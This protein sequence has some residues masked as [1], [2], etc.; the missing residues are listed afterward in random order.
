MLSE[1]FRSWKYS[2]WR[3]TKSRLEKGRQLPNATTQIQPYRPFD[4]LQ[5][6]IL[7]SEFLKNPTAGDSRRI[8]EQIGETRKRVKVE[9]FIIE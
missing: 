2:T 7:E 6:S 5:K 4:D 9:M 8:A 1:S 3:T